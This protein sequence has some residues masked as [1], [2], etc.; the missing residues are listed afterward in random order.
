MIKFYT[1]AHKRPDFIGIQYKSMSNNLGDK[2]FELVVLNNATFD[3]VKN[4]YHAIHEECRK[5]GI[6][7]IDVEYD[8]KIVNSKMLLEGSK[9]IFS[10]RG[11]A[12]ANFA[13]A[14][15]LCWAWETFLYKEPGMIGFIDSDMFFIE[16][17]DINPLLQ[18][19]IIYT[20]QSRDHVHY[21]WNGLFFIY[22]S[23][24]PEPEKLNWWCG[25]IDEKIL[26]V[27]GYT[28]IYMKEHQD[29]INHRPFN[30]H[31]L[32]TEDPSAGFSYANYE[33]YRLIDDVY[34]IIHYRSGSNWNN[35]PPEYHSIK[36]KWIKEKIGV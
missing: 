30:N 21:M 4:D 10:S 7:C 12:N 8:E 27:G 20:P 17:T 16:P 36:T 29:K 31:S 6:Q 1:I 25:I 3:V 35:M 9:N 32:F 5:I 19:D 14:Y 18:Y 26:D 13:C 33:L 23:R 2:N 28:Y 34:R 15:P 22:P 11:Y 24:I